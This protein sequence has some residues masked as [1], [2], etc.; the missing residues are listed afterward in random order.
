MHRRFW[1]AALSIAVA[2][3]GSVGAVVGLEAVAG[4]KT[5]SP[6]PASIMS[7]SRSGIANSYDDALA[8]LDNRLADALARTAER[9]GEWLNLEAA[10]RLYLARA[11]LTGSFDDYNQ[12]QITVRRAFAVA[13]PG[14]GPHMTQA[15]VD[16]AVHRLGATSRSLDKI[17]GY[18]VP[19]LG[20]EKAE[21]TA[22]RGDLQFYSGKYDAA[23]ELYGEADR[24][25]P[26]SSSFRMAVYHSKMGDY[27]KADEYLKQILATKPNAAP[28]SRAFIELHRGILKLDQ[29]QLD[30]ALGHFHKAN[31]AFPGYW[32]IEEHI[33]EV[34]TLKGRTA[35][36]EG[37]YRRIVVRTGHPEFMDALANIAA[38]RGQQATEQHWRRRA[39]GEWQRRLLLF[40]EAAYGHALDH[41][42]EKRDRDCALKLARRNHSARPYG[43]AKLKLAEALIL[44]GYT[45][46]A[47]K[48]FDE[49]TRSG[50]SRR[51]IILAREPVRG[52][53]PRPSTHVR[54]AG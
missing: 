6:A 40:P 21:L 7:V 18:A 27:V 44:G 13:R 51:Q 28:Q 5:P 33:A 42:L 32:L 49:V 19:L 20:E 3:I 15:L 39:V 37:L 16:F 47:E 17:D 29:G 48:L 24:L 54:F 22:L 38:T 11:K 53:G 50:W 4:P 31:A 41:C 34:L 23:L 10:A 1:R 35:Q 46:E 43:D 12:A 52:A 36:A 14:V 26:G 45:N 2:A 8:R 30:G 25:S 9:P